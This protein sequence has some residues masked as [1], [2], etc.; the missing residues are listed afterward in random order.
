MRTSQLLLVVALLGAVA[1]TTVS[2]VGQNKD[3]HKV[4]MTF[5]TRLFTFPCTLPAP[6]GT[7]CLLLF[8][9]G[10]PQYTP[11][12]KNRLTLVCSSGRAATA[13]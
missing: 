9:R 13:R 10:T 8:H 6:L 11:L 3:E 1:V 12:L 2:A 5:T 7:P 4:E